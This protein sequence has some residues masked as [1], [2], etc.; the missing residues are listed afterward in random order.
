VCHH[1]IQSKYFILKYEQRDINL[2]R[3]A[4]SL[5]DGSQIKP[6]KNRKKNVEEKQNLL[7]E[8]N[9]NKND[10]VNILRE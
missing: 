10:F 1:H 8:E 9:F 2:L 7:N 5:K 4:S 6:L 3:K